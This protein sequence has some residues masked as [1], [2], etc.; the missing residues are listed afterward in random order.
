M[1][2]GNVN[3]S[4]NPLNHTSHN[5]NFGNTS[6]LGQGTFGPTRDYLSYRDPMVTDVLNL[7]CAIVISVSQR[8]CA[9]RANNVR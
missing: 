3:Q 1:T 4:V 6:C 8:L 5:R 7:G 9:V 2:L